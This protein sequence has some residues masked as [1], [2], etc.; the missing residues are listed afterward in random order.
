MERAIENFAW[1]VVVAMV[2]VAA[3]FERSAVF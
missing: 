3:W 1:L 2:A